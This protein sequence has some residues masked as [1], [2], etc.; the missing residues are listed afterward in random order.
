MYE[1]SGNVRKLLLK[2]KLYNLK[3]EEG[4]S[5]AEFLKE[6]KDV[7]NQLIAIGGAV[8]NDEIVEYVNA[9][10]ERYEN[11]VSSIGLRDQLPDVTTLMGL[12]L[13]NEARRELRSSKRVVT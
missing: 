1:T 12:S 8:S 11:F 2:S 4:S 7:S 3:L 10:L 13:H 9:L 6:V 5:V